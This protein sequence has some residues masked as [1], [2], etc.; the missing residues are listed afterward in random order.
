MRREDVLHKG[1]APRVAG[2]AVSP[3]VLEAGLERAAQREALLLAL[4]LDIHAD[5]VELLD[6]RDPIADDAVVVEDF[7][8][9]P[10]HPTADYAEVVLRSDVCERAHGGEAERGRSLPIRLPIRKWREA[11]T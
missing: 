1:K 7:L 8:P 4:H 9:S 5:R 10:N 6:P 11:E 2:L 3:L